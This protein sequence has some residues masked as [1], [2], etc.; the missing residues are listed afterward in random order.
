MIYIEPFILYY[1]LGIVGKADYLLNISLYT[2][3][4]AKEQYNNLYLNQSETIQTIFDYKNMILS[5][6]IPTVQNVSEGLTWFDTFTIYI[7]LLD[8]VDQSVCNFLYN[9]AADLQVQFKQR[10]NIN[11]SIIVIVLIVCPFLTFWYV[12]H[13]RRLINKMKEFTQHLSDK[14]AEIK[15]EKKRSEMLLC[16]MLPNSVAEKLRKNETVLPEM[17]NSVTIM[18]NAVEG[19][20]EIVENSMPF[21]VILVLIETK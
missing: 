10:N 16:Q 2:T 13:T 14:S 5:N 9:Y 7:N 15:I 3:R 20:P 1:I 21:E 8:N 6:N 18:F 4:V 12:I 11:V 19:F 17:F